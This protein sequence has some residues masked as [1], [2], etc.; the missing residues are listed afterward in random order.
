MKNGKWVVQ[1][2]SRALDKTKAT[3][4]ADVEPSSA[5]GPGMRG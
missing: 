1:D 4:R 3:K 2:V 5:Q